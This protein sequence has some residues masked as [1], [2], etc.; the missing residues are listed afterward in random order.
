MR[1][2]GPS[3]ESCPE[4]ALWGLNLGQRP[5]LLLSIPRAKYAVRA[6]TQAPLPAAPAPEASVC[7][8]WGLGEVGL[9]VQGSGGPQSWQPK[10]WVLNLACVKVTALK[11]RRWM[12]LQDLGGVAWDS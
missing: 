11:V 8:I 12:G 10:A 1:R 3:S 5:F 7:S 2:G 4:G 6:Q 9:V